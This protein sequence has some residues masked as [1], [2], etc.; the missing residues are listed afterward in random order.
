MTED[1]K[2]IMCT[3]VGIEAEEKLTEKDR[4]AHFVQEMI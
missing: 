4:L 2:K 3:T 1:Q